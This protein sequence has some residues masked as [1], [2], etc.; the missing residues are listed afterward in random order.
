MI[1]IAER[2]HWIATTRAGI[3]AVSLVDL[4]VACE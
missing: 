2:G 4:A 1:R 3:L